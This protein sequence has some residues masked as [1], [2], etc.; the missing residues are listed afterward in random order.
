MQNTEDHTNVEEL[1]SLL[2]AKYTPPGGPAEEINTQVCG[3][4]SV[5]ATDKPQV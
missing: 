5:P 4:S 3:E 2:R 1:A